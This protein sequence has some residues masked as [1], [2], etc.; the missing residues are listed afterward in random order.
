MYYIIHENKDENSVDYEAIPDSSVL[1]LHDVNGKSM[2]YCKNSTDNNYFDSMHYS[3][4][5]VDCLNKM[6]LIVRNWRI[7]TEKEIESI[8]ESLKLLKEA[9]NR[10]KMILGENL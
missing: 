7:E 1:G 2:L 5:E 4:D 3:I 10:A 9:N 8:N 6:T